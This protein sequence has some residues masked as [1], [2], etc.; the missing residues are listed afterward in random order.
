MGSQPIEV[1]VAGYGNIDVFSPSNW[2]GSNIVRGDTSLSFPSTN[3]FFYNT[4]NT[5]ITYDLTS[6]TFANVN[7]VFLTRLPS[8]SNCSAQ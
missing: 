1:D 6:N 5:P 7:Q 2:N 4:G 8:L 3:I